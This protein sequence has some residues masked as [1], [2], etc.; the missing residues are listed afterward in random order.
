MDNSNE[1][2]LIAA[3]LPSDTHITIDLGSIEANSLFT[4]TGPYKTYFDD[5]SYTIHNPYIAPL[6]PRRWW[7]FWKRGK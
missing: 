7:Q 6:Q 1:P 4:M 3:G 5:G 2:W